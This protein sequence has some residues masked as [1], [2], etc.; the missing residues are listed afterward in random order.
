M[1]EY[2]LWCDRPGPDLSELAAPAYLYAGNHDTVVPPSTLTLWRDAI[3][4]VAKVRRYDDA[5]DDV[6]YRHWDQLLADV[7]GYGDY[8]V[9]CWHGRS[10]LVPAAQAVSLR[11][12]GATEGVCGWR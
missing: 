4:N 8:V 5:C 7:A 1:H 6:Q 10:Q 11:D 12:R 2:R 9:L 3:P